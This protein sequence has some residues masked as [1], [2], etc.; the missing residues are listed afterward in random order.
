VSDENRVVELALGRLFR[1]ASR[2]FEPGDLADYERCRTVIL[3]ALDPMP[4]PWA[5][6]PARRQAQGA[7]G[8]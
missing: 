8:D 2:P 4:V 7:Q 3:D 6:V 1:I 5:A